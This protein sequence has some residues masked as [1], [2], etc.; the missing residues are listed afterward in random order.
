MSVLFTTECWK[1][2]FVCFTDRLGEKRELI[3]FDR[4]FETLSAMSEGLQ[5]MYKAF[6]TGEKFPGKMGPTLLE[7]DAKTVSAHEILDRLGL[8]KHDST[9]S[10]TS[11]SPTLRPAASHYPMADLLSFQWGELA[12]QGP[13]TP[14]DSSQENAWTR[15]NPTPS[16]TDPLYPLQ[17]PTDGMQQERGSVWEGPDMLLDSPEDH[18]FPLIPQLPGQRPDPLLYPSQDFTMQTVK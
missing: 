13:P 15:S 12:D 1:K 3:W 4:M 9:S 5:V 7:R 6:Q 11:A 14:P 10:S 17:H 8:I 2:S 16:Q 18:L